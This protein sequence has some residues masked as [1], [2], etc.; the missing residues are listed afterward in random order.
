MKTGAFRRSVSGILRCGAA[1]LVACSAGTSKPPEPSHTDCPPTASGDGCATPD[2]SIDSGSSDAGPD[3]GD[4]S[5]PGTAPDAGALDAGP[6]ALPCITSSD[7]PKGALCA[8]AVCVAECGTPAPGN[9]CAQSCVTPGDCECPAGSKCGVLYGYSPAAI[10][11]MTTWPSVCHIDCD[12]DPSVCPSGTTCLL[13]W[14]DFICVSTA[15]PSGSDCSLQ[16]HLPD[17]D[18]PPAVLGTCAVATDVD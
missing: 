7:C 15:C 16:P 11:D 3:T 14:N 1:V 8:G 17:A 5:A 6:H 4:A 13:S 9:Y 12:H 2:G 10:A 18:S